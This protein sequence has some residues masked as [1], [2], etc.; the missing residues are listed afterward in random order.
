MAQA[1]LHGKL[2]Y[3][4][5]YKVP[6]DKVYE[7]WS[8][9]FSDVQKACP[10]IINNIELVQG[11]WGNEGSIHVMTY[12]IDGKTETCE[13]MVEAVDYKKKF[14]SFK[15]IGGNL[16]DYYRCVKFILGQV[17][18]KADGGSLASWTL[19]YEKLD[20]NVPDP[21]ALRDEAVHFNKAISAYLSH[22]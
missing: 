3:D 1:D 20:E 6:A 4:V 11:C 16:L 5:E 2:Q 19:E 7:F 9:N 15:V 13:E 14:I 10:K 17:S 22:A 8:C 21:I 12:T 18:P